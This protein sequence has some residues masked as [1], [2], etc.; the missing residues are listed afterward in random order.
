MLIIIHGYFAQ[1]LNTTALNVQYG[2]SDASENMPPVF[3]NDT[4]DICIFLGLSV[5]Y[6]TC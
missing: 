3:I 2:E 6:G 1:G 4:G 5:R